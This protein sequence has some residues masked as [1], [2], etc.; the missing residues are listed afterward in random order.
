MPGMAP[1]LINLHHLPVGKGCVKRGVFQ[2]GVLV[3]NLRLRRRNFCF[4]TQKNSKRHFFL[5]KRPLK[6]RHLTGMSCWYLVNGCPN[7]YISRLDT[8]RK[9]SG[10]INQ[11]A[12]YDHF[13][14]HPSTNGTLK[15]K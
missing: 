1:K 7:P 6:G 10:E 9:R 11:L 14:G 2:F 12:S 8:S 15:K 13:H 4:E 3:H 5:G